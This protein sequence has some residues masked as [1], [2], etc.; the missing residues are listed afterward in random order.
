MRIGI[1]IDDTITNTWEYFIPI[2][3]KKFN[4]P[5][6]KIKE[7]PPYYGSVKDSVSIDEYF[8]LI[9]EYESL[10]KDVPLKEDVKEILTKLKEEGNTIIFITARSNNT[11]TNPYLISKEYLDNNSIPYDKII[12]NAREKGIVCKEEKIDLFIDDNIKNCI[13]VSNQGI[14]VLMMDACYNLLDKEFTHMN[15]WKQVYEYINNRWY[16][17]K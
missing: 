4:I 5:E 15:N 9:R 13:D 2:F 7:L 6:D 17:G 10:M 16:N 12:V 3:S 8:N 11:Y 1:D 14:E